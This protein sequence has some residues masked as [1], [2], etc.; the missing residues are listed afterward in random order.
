MKMHG[1]AKKFVIPSRDDDLLEE[2]DDFYTI[3]KR[4]QLDEIIS[5]V[6]QFHHDIDAGRW[7]RVIDRFDH[8]FF[9]IKPFSEGEPWRLRAQLISVLNTGIF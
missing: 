4:P 5:K 1:S 2:S 7:S 3:S 8:L 9:T 6:F